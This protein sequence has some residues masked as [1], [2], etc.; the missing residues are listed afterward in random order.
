MS[1]YHCVISNSVSVYPL[2][3]K[4]RVDSF[5]N[6][7]KELF[8]E[9]NIIRLN[10]I[11]W[12]LFWTFC[13]SMTLFDINLLRFCLSGQLRSWTCPQNGR[14]TSRLCSTHRSPPST[15]PTS[16][17]SCRCPRPRPRH[18]CSELCP[19]WKRIQGWERWERALGSWSPS[20]TWT[21]H[22]NPL[23]P[24]HTYIHRQTLIWRGAEGGRRVAAQWPRGS[25][26]SAT[27]HRDEV[28]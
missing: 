16:A 24:S 20:S 11:C 27:V 26:S 17:G 4:N 23:D 3:K 15:P 25:I 19:K 9:E 18:A 22:T 1:R 6:V 8:A 5:S 28:R 10:A 12:D 7:H 2:K 13:H 14:S 21:A